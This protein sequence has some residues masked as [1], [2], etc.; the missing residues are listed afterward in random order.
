M[1]LERGMERAHSRGSAVIVGVGS[2][3]LASQ[4]KRGVGRTWVSGGRRGWAKGGTSVLTSALPIGMAVVL[5]AHGLGHALGVLP[6]LGVKLSGQHSEA[7]WVLRSLLG[8]VGLRVVGVTLWVGALLAFVGAGLGLLGW[9]VAPGKWEL[10]A[11]IA[12]SL[13]LAT[14]LLFWQG[15]PFFFPNKVGALTW[16]F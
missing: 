13:S 14:I 15:L 16:P 7:S 9:Y 8:T 4:L 3:V 2:R 1:Q 11:L 6:M 10:L 12:C 5:V